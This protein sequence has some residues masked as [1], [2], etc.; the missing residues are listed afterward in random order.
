MGLCTARPRKGLSRIPRR[1]RVADLAA[2]LCRML[3]ILAKRAADELF[4]QARAALYCQRRK[5]IPTWVRFQT[6]ETRSFRK[7]RGRRMDFI[8]PLQK[9]TF[10]SCR[11]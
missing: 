10:F 1:R 6:L 7:H 5:A 9:R 11:I 4:R 3:T 8:R 2:Q